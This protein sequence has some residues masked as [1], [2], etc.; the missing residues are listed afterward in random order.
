MRHQVKRGLWIDR[1]IKIRHTELK[2]MSLSV[3]LTATTDGFFVP[4]DY[5]RRWRQ[6]EIFARAAPMEI[7]LGCGDGSFLL[8]LARHHPER[9]FLGV[10]RLLGRARKVARRIRQA[11]LSNVKVLRLES[12]YT[13]EW[14]L[15]AE[16]VSRLHLLCPDPWP[17]QRHQERRLIQQPFLHALWRCLAANG[18]FLF[19]TDDHAYF[20]WTVQH[21]SQFAQFET[22]PWLA[23]DFFYPKT[24][25]Q[26]LWESQGKTLQALRCRKSA[27]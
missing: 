25:F 21:V 13:I 1:C 10:E 12:R 26:L 22:L 9:N 5:F 6:E 23:T 27:E 19:K 14:L 24:D 8:E 4:T 11:R 15:E 3:P 18:E 16:S 7:D 2:A 20:D 17:K